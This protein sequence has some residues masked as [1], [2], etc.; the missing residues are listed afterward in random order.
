MKVL[1]LNEYAY[2]HNVSGA[3]YSMQALAEGLQESGIE[4]KILSP[5]LSVNPTRSLLAGKFPFPKKIKPGQILS[6]LWFNN[7]FFWLYSAYWI[8]QT[9]KKE[10][11]D[12]LHVHGKYILP[13]AI[14]AGWLTHK[15]V[16]AT[17]R[18]FKFLCPLAL[19]F[20]HQ[21]KKCGL[22]YYINKEIPEYQERYGK[23][24]KWKLVLA[25]LWQ[26][27]LKWFL[28][29]CQQII[30]VSPQLA[31]IYQD[32]GVKKVVS[33]YNLPPFSAKGRSAS[34]GDKQ[35]I[36]SVG[37][38]SYGKGTDC[39][40]KAAE[41]LPQ[42]QFIFAGEINPS[43]KLKFP[44]NCQYLGKLS[45]EQTLKLYARA[46][47]FVILSRWP[48]PLSRAGLEALSFGLP[49]VASDRGGNQEIVKDNGYLVDPENIELVAKTIVKA[50]NNQTLLSPKSLDLL[51]T[52]F[53]R[54][55][56]L[57][58]HLN[59]YQKII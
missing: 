20:T 25:K 31:Q 34:G 33:I 23:T 21:Q 2:P 44:H 48:E 46:S 32:N 26:Y 15:P 16:V 14:I 45:H 57:E 58:S 41:Q 17:V 59:L 5:D 52:R 47:V 43:L 13:G 8:Y 29:C 39:L 4:V 49:I 18:D 55:K 37:K 40:I 1:F 9:V 36:L 42:Y 12:L 30:A 51:H 7:P 50:I 56:T 3:E 19:C 27:K 35:V 38:L 24:A 28:N 22:S 6:P 54:Q 10:K 11:I 53:N